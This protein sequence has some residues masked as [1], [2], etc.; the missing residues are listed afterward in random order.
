MAQRHYSRLDELTKNAFTLHTPLVYRIFEPFLSTGCPKVG[1]FSR[2]N[3][4]QGVKPFGH[5]KSSNP[6]K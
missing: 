1:R 4:D 5:G 2:K 3:G 6:R